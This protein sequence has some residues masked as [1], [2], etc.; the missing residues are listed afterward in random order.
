MILM[1]TLHCAAGTADINAA[2]MNG[3]DSHQNF[4]R[5]IRSKAL[6]MTMKIPHKRMMIG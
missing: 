1:W 4:S 3:T 5:R 6:P 2:Q